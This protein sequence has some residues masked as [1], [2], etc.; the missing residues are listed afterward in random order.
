LIDLSPWHTESSRTI[1]NLTPWFTIIK[2]TI[3]HPSG[4]VVSDYYRIKAADCVFIS[5]RRD[6]GCILMERHYKQCR[7]KVIL[8][9]P[10][11][12]VDKGEDPLAAAQRELLEETGFQAAEWKSSGS[13]VLDGTRGIGNAHFFSAE[14]IRKVAELKKCGMEEFEP[15]FLSAADI[16]TAVSEGQIALLPDIGILSMTLGKLTQSSTQRAAS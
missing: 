13:F 9:S 7:G 10:A 12:G 3:R 14:K 4:R 5:V 1:F 15:L 6:D 16:R 2:D 8:T 11:G